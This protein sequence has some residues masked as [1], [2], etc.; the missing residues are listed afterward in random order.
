MKTSKKP[1]ITPQTPTHSP[2]IYGPAA[3]KKALEAL[4]PAL[5]AIPEREIVTL[6]VD[7]EAA[8]YAALGVAGF[9]ASP[10]VQ[11]R[12]ARLPKEELDMTAVTGL[13][14]AC[15]ATLY[16]LAEARAA[17]ALET[18]VKVPAE[19]VAEAAAVETRMQTLC[20][21]QFS[22][23]PELKPELDRLRP[24]VGHR[25]LA[26]DLLG[27]ARIYDLRHAV[28]KADQKYYRPGD[29]MRARELAGTIIQA[30]SSALTPRARAAYDQ[31][32]RAWTLLHR[33]YG[34]VRAAG[35]WLFRADPACN[36]RFPSLFSA[37]RPNGGRPKKQAPASSA[38]GGDGAGAP[39]P[40]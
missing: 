12:F 40:G 2:P 36:E 1:Q 17:G 8:T 34:E 21:Y 26:N 28:V 6:R 19:I 9:L 33:R 29:A 22:D 5:E 4:A 25:D 20:E 35:T 16:A 23:D 37:A 7:V 13:E 31:Y 39:P 38:G 11:A 10:Q 14:A 27:Y 15:F 32:A 3:G 24:G 18:D 30:L